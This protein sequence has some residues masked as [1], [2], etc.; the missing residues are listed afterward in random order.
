MGCGALQSCLRAFHLLHDGRP[1]SIGVLA[2]YA[3]FGRRVVDLTFVHI[4]GMF[5]VAS[6]VVGLSLL[7][8]LGFLETRVD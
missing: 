1:S 5:T 8:L 2:S 6:V 7:E 3:V 4:K